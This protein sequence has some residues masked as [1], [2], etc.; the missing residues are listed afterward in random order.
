MKQI[1][2]GELAIEFKINKS[3]LAY[4]CTMGLLRPMAK[5]GRM[6]VFDYEETKAVIKKINDLQKGGKT[7]KEI[8]GLLK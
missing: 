7:I 2:L 3:R 6:N 5:I 8:K 1:S 4:Y